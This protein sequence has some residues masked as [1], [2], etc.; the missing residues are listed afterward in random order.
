MRPHPGEQHR[1]GRGARFHRR[2][3]VKRNGGALA[4]QRLRA[5]EVRQAG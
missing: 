5:A 3:H 1:S 4:Q 2:A